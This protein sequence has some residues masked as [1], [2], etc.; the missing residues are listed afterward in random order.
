MKLFYLFGLFMGLSTIVYSQCVIVEDSIY[1]FEY[2]GISYELVKEPLSWLD[3]VSCA[4]ERGGILAEIES[5]EEQDTIFSIISSLPLNIG[6]TNAGDGGGASYIWLGAND[7][8]TEG[9]WVWN[10]DND[11]QYAHFWQGKRNGEIVN[12]LFVN[13]GQEP[14]DYYGQDALGL[15]ITNWPLGIA[16]QWNDIDVSNTLYYL[17]EYNSGMYIEDII[18]DNTAIVDQ[19]PEIG[20]NLLVEKVGKN[21]LIINTNGSDIHPLSLEIISTDGNVLLTEEIFDSKVSINF[22]QFENELIIVLI[23]RNEDILYSELFNL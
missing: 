10:G 17:I 16:G 7:I 15:A 13:W 20:S 4:I 21:N 1:S 11:D 5:Q 18:I 22:D 23:K 9:K 14:D 6:E 8:T 2:N 19:K 3:A 12:D